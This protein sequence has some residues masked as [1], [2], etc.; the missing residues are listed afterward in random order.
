[1]M[2]SGPHSSRSRIPDVRPFDGVRKIEKE[3]CEVEGRNRRLVQGP[4][5]GTV[6]CVQ[7][8]VPTG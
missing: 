4:G 7:H 1:M 3:E 2:K 5:R 6:R 8:H